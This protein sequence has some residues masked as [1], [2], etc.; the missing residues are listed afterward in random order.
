MFLR[1]TFY[2]FPLYISVDR[3]IYKLSFYVL[4]ILL[5]LEIFRF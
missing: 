2:T 4:D 1:C 3:E 5:V